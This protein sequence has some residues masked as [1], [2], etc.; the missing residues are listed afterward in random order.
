[1]T[2]DGLVR[3]PCRGHCEGRHHVDAVR[4]RRGFLDGDQFDLIAHYAE[5]YWHRGWRVVAVEPAGW[6]PPEPEFDAVA[7]VFVP[8]HNP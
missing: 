7:I 2:P 3:H 4:E 6:L 1:M 5:H 8:V